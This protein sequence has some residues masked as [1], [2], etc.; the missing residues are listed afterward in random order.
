MDVVLITDTDVNSILSKLESFYDDFKSKR[1]KP[2]KLANSI[3]AFMNSSGGDL[4]IGAEEPNGVDRDSYR[5]DGFEKLED[6]NDIFSV[7]QEIDP[8]GNH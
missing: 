8:S 7:L 2:A 6:A 3:S 5:W 1:I 4:Y